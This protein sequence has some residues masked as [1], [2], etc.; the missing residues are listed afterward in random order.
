VLIELFCEMLPLRRRYERFSDF[1]PTGSAPIKHF[2]SQK[3]TA[4]WSFVWYNK[5][6]SYRRKTALQGELILVKTGRLER[7]DN[8]LRTL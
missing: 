5:Y 7:W 2:S 1:A 3:T 8:I 4:K 6:L